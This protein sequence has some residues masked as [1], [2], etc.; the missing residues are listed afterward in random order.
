MAVTSDAV[1]VVGIPRSGTTWLLSILENHPDCRAVTADMLGIKVAQPTKE[2]GLFVRGFSDEEIV[3]RWARLPDDKLLV[4]KTPVHIRCTRRIRQLLGAKILLIRRHPL[5]VLNS[6]LKP[7]VFW[8]DSP[9]TLERALAEYKKFDVPL[10]AIAPDHF[11]RYE[12]F[13]S[14]PQSTADGVY[15]ALGLSLDHTQEIVERTR[16]GRSLP[17]RLKTVFDTGTSGQGQRNFSQADLEVIRASI[18][19]GALSPIA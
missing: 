3:R 10:D 19:E 17:D 8:K 15:A 16:F 2:T 12:D 1:F 6:M 11:V 18:G 4:E 13:W 5:D 14:D 7:N 9:K